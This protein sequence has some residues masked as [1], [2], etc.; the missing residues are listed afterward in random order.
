MTRGPLPF[1]ALSVVVQLAA[2]SGNP[3]KSGDTAGTGFQ[4]LAPDAMPP[5]RGGGGP[6]T[7]FSTD[8]LWQGCAPLHGGDKDYKHH[9]LVVTWRGHLLMPWSP[10][11]GSG[12]MTLF[13]MADPCAPTH[14]GEGWSQTMRESH[15]IGLMHLPEGTELDG[16]D[17]AGDYAAVTGVLGVEIWDLSDETSLEPLSYVE[18]EDVFYP[19]SYARVVLSVFWQYPWLYVGA[20][21][22]G[23]LV[24]DASDPSSPFEVMRFDPDIRVAGVFVLGDLLLATSAEGRESVLYDVG[25]PDDPQPIPGGRFENADHTGVAK[26]AYHGNLVGDMALFARKEGGGGFMMYDVSAPTAPTFVTDWQSD[27][28]GGYVFYDE[29]YIFVGESSVG[30]V[31]DA[32]ATSAVELVGEVHLAGDLDTLTPYGNVV[33][34]SVDDEAED[35]IAT[36]IFPWA[37]APDSTG[38][39]VLRVRPVDGATG[40]SPRVRIGVGFNEFIEPSS[41]FAG[42]IRLWDSAGRPVDGWGSGQETIASLSPKEDLIPGETYTVEVMAGGVRDLNDNALAETVTTTFSVAGTP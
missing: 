8:A 26:E 39:E 24:L 4:F 2:C 20:A 15:A 40:I 33:V 1:A 6:A 12:G 22:N 28:N 3:D 29:G 16:V 10:E 11:L 14:V 35:D 32:R 34:A 37:E 7:S 18:L 19:D 21:D 30:R 38:P 36:M 31:Y 42:S 9:N 27:G 17:I 25:V 41:V 23:V 5:L 13:D